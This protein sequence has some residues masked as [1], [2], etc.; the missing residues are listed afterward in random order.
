[1]MPPDPMAASAPTN[2]TLPFVPG[3]SRMPP[4]LGVSP[5]MPP[6]PMAASAPTNNPP[7]P[8]E[9]APSPVRPRDPMQ[10][11]APTEIGAYEAKRQF[12]LPRSKPKTDRKKQTADAQSKF[13]KRTYGLG[14]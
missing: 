14:S 7:P 12:S 4:D 9:I 2:A 10:A 1:M 8:M 13:R 11:S 3:S 6:D 5:L